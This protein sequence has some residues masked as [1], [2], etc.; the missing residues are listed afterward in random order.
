MKYQWIEEH[1][2][3]EE[4]SQELGCDVRSITKGDIVVGYEESTDEKG[5]PIQ[6]PIT[7]KGIEIEFGVEPTAEQLTKLDMALLGFKR[8]GNITLT[9]EFDQ[10]KARVDDLEKSSLEP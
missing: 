1:K 9:D 7:R 8:E 3:C 4:L 2:T 10:L 5:N 6:V